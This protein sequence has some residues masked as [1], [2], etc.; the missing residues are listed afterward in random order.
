MISDTRGGH[1]SP[2]VYT[3][4]KDVTYSVKSL[5]ITSLGLVGETVKGP[6]FQSIPIKDWTEFTEY[7]GGTSP[8][9]YVGTGLP[10][11]ELPYIAKEY[12]EESNNLNVVRVLGISGYENSKAYTI[13]ATVDGKTIPVVVL[14]S[15]GDYKGITDGQVC[16]GSKQEKFRQYV[17]TIT[18]SPYKGMEYDSNCTLAGSAYTI[19]LNGTI[20]ALTD[21]TK[22]AIDDNSGKEIG[23]FTLTVTMESF[24]DA[25]PNPYGNG[26]AYTYGISLLQEDRDYIYNVFS[27]NPLLGSAPVYVESVYD[28][29]YN[30]LIQ[31][32]ET[33]KTVSFSM[34]QAGGSEMTS[35]ASSVEE[36]VICG[37]TTYENYVDYKESYR[38]AVTPWI[39][40]EV[41]SATEEA[42][43]L[44]KLFRF[45]TIS[46]GNASNYQVKISVQR[47]RPDEGLF[48]IWV[49]DF[50]D[51]D[52][53]PMVL[54]KYSNL[55]LVEG[56]SNYIGLK[57]GTFDGEYEVKS[58]FVTVE[59]S[60]EE[61]V[62][63]SV[64]CGFLGYPVPTYG[65][66]KLEMSY[67]TL[68]DTTIKPKRQYFG[69]N[70][71]VLDEDVLNYKGRMNYAFEPS[72][73]PNRLTNGFHLDAVLS[74]PGN[75]DVTPNG[76]KDAKIYVD[77]VEF[78]AGSFT[79]VDNVQIPGKQQN[80]PRVNSEAYMD[81][82]IYADINTRKFTVYPYG[83]FDGWDIYRDSRTNT[84]KY[85]AT[86][87]DIVSGCPFD[88]VNAEKVAAL[89]PTLDLGLAST[90]ITSDYYAYLAGYYQFANPEDVDINL[91]AT[92][93]VT[94]KDNV[95]LVEDA[96]DI[97][98]DPEDGRGGD[99]LYVIDAPQEGPA[100]EVVADLESSEIDSSYA[101][102]Y[103]PWVKYFDAN[104][105]KYIMLPPTKD[106]VRNMAE[107]DNKANP[108]FA[109]AGVNR[110]KMNVT[111]AE[112]K[113]KLLDE[114]ELYGNR[115]NPIK[116]FAKDGVLVWGNKTL[117][118]KDTPLNRINVRRLMIRVKKLVVLASRNMIFDQMDNTLEQQFRSLVT[119]ILDDVKSKRGIIDYRIM[120]ESTPE[121]RDQ[122][123]LPARILIKPMQA[124][125][126]ISISFVVYPESVAFDEN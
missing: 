95:L 30:D 9:K 21:G 126:Y 37:I 5:G 85:K 118:S 6:A 4:E 72:E 26:S 70:S 59:I 13:E 3:E 45:Y 106:V 35:D 112:Q 50:Y 38:C 52:V 116:T 12:L 71:N 67:N 41:K 43:N 104:A 28:Y 47:I 114:D 92:P 66:G 64:P 74:M 75:T 32:T 124:L 19:A 62:E 99:A 82:T 76:L 29:A 57:I 78:S 63:S 113:T 111:K 103:W 100:D 14:R 8:E 108:W 40:S 120:T 84:D 115:I 11:Y 77:S 65:A 1:V 51:T 80:M 54:E 55:S 96:L 33:G 73:T 34:V 56:S 39:V 23:R 121:T 87:Y 69:L 79:T 60:K 105:N 22:E 17:D 48:D 2:G 107:T 86:K 81:N 20:S 123:I 90:A 101:A 53:T 31:N 88:Y 125:E 94:F 49:R 83:G 16:E 7:F 102:T 110:G 25:N 46:D 97:I 93:G 15:K 10:K 36:A 61:G 42:I 58:K 98:E 24:G 68:L 27:I 117:Y 122:H 44:K 89:D 119:P 18:L 91:F 109:P